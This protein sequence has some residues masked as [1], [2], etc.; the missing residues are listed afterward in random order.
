[1]PCPY[2]EPLAVASAPRHTNARLPLIHEYDGLCRARPEPLGVAPQHR[3]CCCN[4]GYSLGCCEHFPAA[5][6]RSSFRY[7]VLRHAAAALEILCIEEQNYAPVRWQAT[8]YSLENG[9]LEPEVA[10]T[11]MRAQVL[12]F[13]RSYL[14]RFPPG[15]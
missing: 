8:R 14:Q 10:D 1:M 3:F 11:C 6:T 4:H 13:C 9:L 7:T 5:D 15:S 2:F 12:A